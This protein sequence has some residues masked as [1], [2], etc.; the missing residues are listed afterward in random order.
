MTQSPKVTTDDVDDVDAD[1]FSE[2][3][4]KYGK[5][6]K[7]HHIIISNGKPGKKLHKYIELEDPYP[8]KTRYL[9]NSGMMMI[10]VLRITY[11]NKRKLE[12]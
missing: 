9:R 3:D 7:F 5:E 8:R 4:K 10:N 6:A 11:R 1:D 12:Q 2:T